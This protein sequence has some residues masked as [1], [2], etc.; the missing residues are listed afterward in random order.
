[1]DETREDII[2][3]APKATVSSIAAAADERTPRFHGSAGEYFRIWI[4][5]LVLSLM[6]LGVYSAWATVR[7]RRYFY[8]NTEV[9]GHRFDFHGDPVAIL[10]GRALAVIVLLAY[11]F[12]TE[13][14]W[15]ITLGAFAIMALALPWVIV[16][17]LRF[18]LA[19]TS[20]RGLRFGFLGTS[21]QSYRY[22][23]IPL[24]LGALAFGFYLYVLT[25][26][27]L[28]DPEAVARNMTTIGGAFIALVV[29]S[30]ALTPLLWFR[31]RSFAM[32]HTRFGRHRFE[33]PLRLGVF[34]KAL[35][36]AVGLGIAASFALIIGVISISMVTMGAG[37]EG[38]PSFIITM[39]VIYGLAVPVY[40]VPFAAWHCITTNHV[41]SETRL[42][43]LG[44]RMRLDAWMYWW[45]LVSNAAAALV[46]LGM[47]IPWAKVRMVRYKLSCLEL[48]GDPRVFEAGERD[49]PSALGDELGEAFDFDLGF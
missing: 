15:G 23:G 29:V 38:A 46:T 31:I 26:L 5:N 6:T 22:I 40:M 34:W 35:A 19:N 39:V 21:A 13:F 27:D 7:N 49:D 17:T 42:E 24:L 48:T 47:A 14:H 2:E 28:E 3:P 16:R 10:K 30:L 18:R 12:G 9:F 36:I 20:H 25:T 1:M 44:F 32:N 41:I 43:E 11:V 8:G 33:A 37:G 4:V 45:L